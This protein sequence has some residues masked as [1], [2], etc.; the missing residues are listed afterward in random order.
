MHKLRWQEKL[1]AKHREAC[2]EVLPMELNWSNFDP[3]RLYG[4]EQQAP[5]FVVYDD[6][7]ERVEL[8]QEEQEAIRSSCFNSGNLYY[9]EGG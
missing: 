8:Q 6:N 4:E 9:L 7:G 5:E 3:E 2:S 1:K